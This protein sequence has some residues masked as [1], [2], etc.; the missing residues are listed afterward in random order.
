MIAQNPDDAGIYLEVARVHEYFLD[1]YEMRKDKKAAE[2]AV[3]KA[4]D[5]AQLND[6][7]ADAHSLLADLYGRKISLGSA[8]FAGPKFGP[9][10]KEENAKA[11]ALDEQE[12]SRLGQPWPSVPDDPENV[13][14]RRHQAIDSFQKSLAIDSLQDETWVWLAKAFQK[15]GDTS[16]A[17]DAIQHALSLNRALVLSG[18]RPRA[19]RNREI[20][21][22][23]QASLRLHIFSNAPSIQVLGHDLLSIDR[24]CCVLLIDILIDIRHA[25]LFLSE[26]L[27]RRVVD[28]TDTIALAAASLSIDYKLPMADAIIY[29]TAQAHQAELITSDA[30]FSGLP[31]VTLI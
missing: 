2:E 15:Q 9:K 20:W 6:K 22:A 8:V 3:D 1:V 24:E 31:G 17:R 14:W 25:S 5:A 16:K 29:A 28:L 23:M 18:R 21:F 26:A 12:S 13:C 30:H 11:M 19:W 10:V 4:I 27:R 7:S